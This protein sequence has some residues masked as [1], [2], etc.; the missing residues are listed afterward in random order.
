[1]RTDLSNSFLINELC[2][3]LKTII[4]DEQNLLSH[5]QQNK[6]LIF[7]FNPHDMLPY[8]VFGN[9]LEIRVLCLSYK[10]L[11]FNTA[12]VIFEPFPN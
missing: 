6:A 12:T 4:E 2:T 9:I 11:S 1:M 10:C 8:A 7:A 5:S 3:G